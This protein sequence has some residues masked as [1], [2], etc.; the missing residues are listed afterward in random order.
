MS[1]LKN[2]DSVKNLIFFYHIFKNLPISDEK[3][4]K[5]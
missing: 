2:S 4:M 3:K 1:R 5:A